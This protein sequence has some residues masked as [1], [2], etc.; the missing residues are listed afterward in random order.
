MNKYLHQFMVVVLLV[1]FVVFGASPV[2]A[3]GGSFDVPQ[4]DSHFEQVQPD[5]PST[6]E[7][8]ID[9][10]L[11]KKNNP[12][13][14]K[15]IITSF[16]NVG[17][18]MKETAVHIWQKTTEFVSEH[19]LLTSFFIGIT[20][21][22]IY[23]RFSKGFW[24]GVMG[25]IVDTIKG[26]IDLFCHPINT[27]KG[28]VYA[29]SHPVQTGKAVWRAISDSWEQD[30][31][32]GD[33]ESRGYWL[34]N[35]FGQF[36]LSFAG[37]KGADKAAKFSKASMTG[38]IGQTSSINKKTNL[39]RKGLQKFHF[40]QAITRIRSSFSSLGQLILKNKV[41]ASVI[42]VLGVTGGFITLNPEVA[43]QVV[44][45]ITVTAE[46]FEVKSA[47]KKA[48]K[49]FSYKQSPKY[50]ASI[51][52]PG[53]QLF[54][55]LYR[56]DND[57]YSK[58]RPSQKGNPIGKAYIDKKTGDLYPADINGNISVTDHVLNQNKS[59]SPFISVTPNKTN[60]L[61]YGENQI[62]IDFKSLQR[63]IKSG[64]LK[65]V[66]IYF[67]DD[68]IKDLQKSLRAKEKEYQDYISRGGKSQKRIKGYKEKILK[69]KNAVNNTKRD[70]EVLI[71]GIIPSKYIKGPYKIKQ[72]S[73]ET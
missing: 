66:E 6:K 17:N 65:G 35:V 60:D 41:A 10:G 31:V 63:D 25:A 44:N 18:K 20:I 8:Q 29:L 57:F 50:L 54:D 21:I 27:I 7:E 15:R 30:I 51:N 56:S 1:L 28:I 34:G 13:F 14:W 45:K 16:K 68:I 19:K 70:S 73:L 5:P 23:A 2:F 55:C 37:T 38:K 58:S 4:V 52:L 42:T 39:V 48:E 67:Q 9:S 59:K 22:S 3:T 11:P 40:P 53:N 33:A 71:K 32:H 26:V 62:E 36:V 64:K 61:V 49:C 46:K 69:L 47:F 24:K 12:G 43:L 72:N